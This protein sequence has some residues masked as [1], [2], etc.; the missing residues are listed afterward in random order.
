MSSRVAVAVGL[1]PIL[2]TLSITAAPVQDGG[3]YHIIKKIPVGGDGGWDYAFVDT[4]G[5]RLYVSH[6]TKAV[7]IDLDRH[8]NRNVVPEDM[9]VEGQSTLH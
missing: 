1:L 8:V 5:H 2:L 3:G 4:V 6:A 7:V 9:G